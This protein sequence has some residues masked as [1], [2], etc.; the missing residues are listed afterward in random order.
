MTNTV[1]KAIMMRTKL[2]NKFLRLKTVETRVAYNKQRNL[3]VSLIRNAKKVFMRIL[4]QILLQIT[5][6]SGNKLNLF[7][8]IKHPIVQS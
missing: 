8:Q 2:R 3:C 6:N 1:Y 5:E 4:I 7:S